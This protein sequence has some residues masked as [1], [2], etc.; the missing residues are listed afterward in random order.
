MDAVGR[1]LEFQHTGS[2]R[3]PLAARWLPELI[4]EQARRRP[5]ALAV[6]CGDVALSFREL[7]AE[8]DRVAAALRSVEVQPDTVVGVLMNRSAELVV[9]LLA[10]LK[11]GAAYLALSADDP[12]R[13]INRIAQD[14]RISV[15]LVEE[16]LADLA[17]D[18]VKV[19]RSGDRQPAGRLSP[20]TCVSVSGHPDQL[21]YLSYTSG[22]TGEPKGV[23]VSHRAVC[24]LVHGADWIDIRESDVFLQVA[25]VGFDLS[26]AEIFGALA[27]GCRLAV[28]PPGRIDLE[29]LAETVR[30]E[31]VTVLMLA[32]GLLHQ[33]ITSQLKAFAG[34]RHVVAGGD[35]A[36]RPH[37]ERL[38]AAYPGLVYTNG[39]GPTENTTFTAC[40]TTDSRPTP[41]VVPIGRAIGGTRVSV[42]DHRLNPVPVGVVG[43]LY[44]SGDGLARGY[45][46]Q[47]AKTAAR[48]IAAPDAGA[49]GERMY[50]TGDLVRWG[51]DHQL[52]FIGRAD[53]QVKVQGFRVELGAVANAFAEC[54]GVDQAVAVMQDDGT[55]E[56]RLV[57]FVVPHDPAHST[58]NLGSQL[59]QRVRSVLPGYMIPW[60][61]VVCDDLPLNR[62]GK[63]DLRS[64]PTATRLPRNVWSEFVEPSTSA[65]H[66]I[67]Q[68][69]GDVL[70]VE[71][72]GV[73][74][75]FFD[76][77]GHSLLA[78][79]LLAVLQSELGIDIPARTLYLQPTV[80]EL[81][82]VL[83]ELPKPKE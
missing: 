42:L 14:A 7:D 4:S 82:A 44:T 2:G 61:V 60:A 6:T 22:S 11:S 27:N 59:R 20:Q 51:D 63:V 5:D 26:T 68:L 69:W 19:V 55:G 79:E 66:L 15:V 65:E 1:G 77:G 30:A 52:E 72:I 53:Q 75:D 49:P 35:V 16:S 70:G 8:A 74:D 81:A 37:V 71:P 23:G 21:A 25:P 64:L 83:G 54:P 28:L 32:T 57:V 18:G 45:Y 10:I 12:P 56:K 13:R 24:R 46:G 62:N 67:A 73:H 3:A 47:P 43:E 9:S 34:V 78:A 36:S 58:G 33:M 40:W 31:G 76:L 41:A 48:F 38:L 29:E 50:R 80:A 39:Y 17:P